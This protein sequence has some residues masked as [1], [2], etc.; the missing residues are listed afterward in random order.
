MVGFLDEVGLFHSNT[1]DRLKLSIF[2]AVRENGGLRTNEGKSLLN[3][4]CELAK[5]AQVFPQ[6]YKLKNLRCDFSQP[7]EGGAF[8]DIYEGEYENQKVCLKTVRVFGKRDD[9]QRL[10][11]SVIRTYFHR[12]TLTILIGLH[13]GAH[14]VGPPFTSQYITILWCLW[15]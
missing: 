5:S 6:Y 15:M 8:A 4:L 9:A 3:L 1:Y 12:R 7:R 13:E 11:V 14:L 10:R 2:Q